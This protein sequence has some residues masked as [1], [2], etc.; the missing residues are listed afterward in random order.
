[1]KDWIKN[2]KIGKKLMA[3]FAII[4][5]LYNITMITAGTNI[6]SLAKKHGRLVQWSFANVENSQEIRYDL[7]CKPTQF[8]ASI[9]FDRY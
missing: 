5:I 9:G 7:E 2:L 1:M 8:A 6:K 3:A 4:I